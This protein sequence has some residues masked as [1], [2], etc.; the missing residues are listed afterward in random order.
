ME[1]RNES[2]AG[3]VRAG[4]PAGGRIVVRQGFYEGLELPLDADW[5]VIGRGKAAHF[6]LAELTLSREHAAFGWDGS[7]FFVQDLG[8]T[9]GTFVN[10]VRETRAAL[11]DG[12]DVQIG[13]LLLRVALPP[14]RSMASPE[15]V[16]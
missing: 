7:A 1:A 9:N 12:D 2:P 3:P 6:W 14:E 4:V 11:R 16:S 5:L 13:R 8:S 15:G 10:G